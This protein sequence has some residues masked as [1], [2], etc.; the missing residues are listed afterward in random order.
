MG[1]LGVSY[2]GAAFLLCLT[3]PNLLWIRCGPRGCS[4]SRRAVFCWRRSGRSRADFTAGL[5]GVSA[6]G[7]RTAGSR[8]FL[9]G[10]YGRA[11]WLLAGMAAFGIGHIGIHLRQEAREEMGI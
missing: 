4:P 5:S 3:V 8:V 11:V 7:G 1:P 10:I 2:V 9:L 6:A